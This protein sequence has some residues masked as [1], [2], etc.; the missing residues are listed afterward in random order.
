M[1]LRTQILLGYGL[2]FLSAGLVLAWAVVNLLRLGTAS[3]AILS[4]NY[5]SIEAAEHMR[6]ALERQDSAV[7]LYVLGSEAEGARQFEANEG[8]FHRWFGRA[9]DNVTIPGEQAILA[10]V[11][12]AYSAYA[13][14]FTGLVE[15]G[16]AGTAS[17]RP[18]GDRLAT[19]RRLYQERMLPSF[20]AAEDRVVD[21]R[22]LNEQTMVAASERAGRV[23]ERAVW[24]VA[25]VS[26][27]ALV[28]GL[29]LALLLA[30]RIVRPVGQMRT[31]AER[32]G[33][34]DLDVAVPAGTSDELGALAAQFN[35]MTAQLRSYRDLN[36]ERVVAE[37]R[38]GAAVIDSVDDGL[39]VV[40]ADLVVDRMNPAA[41]EALGVDPSLAEGRPLPNVV[42]DEGLLAAVR[43]AVASA[44]AGEAKDRE[45]ED[46][47][48][49]PFLSIGRDGAARHYQYVATPVRTPDGAALGVILLLRDVTAL[50]ELDRLKSEFVAT[51]SHELKTPLTSM[52]MSVGL[53]L[54]RAAG[55]L[56]ERERDLLEA[57]AEDVDRLK[58]LVHDL[59][60]LS[61]IEAGRIELD[62]TAVA[63]PALVDRALGSLRLQADEAGV[64]LSSDLPD[65]LPPVFADPTR[66]AW[67]VTNLVSNALRYTDRGGH[68]VVSAERRGDRVAVSVADDGEG[69]PYAMQGRIFDKFVQVEGARSVGG[70]GLG[71]AI[72][73]ELVR[74][75]GGSI[76]VESAPG[77]GS[78]FTFT[79]PTAAEVS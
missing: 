33:A 78:T 56:S 44:E 25:L 72:S 63:V 26:G 24:S 47:E 55:K 45:M 7:L 13:A 23:A 19:A 4:E 16:G 5:R 11:D 21:L 27:L 64:V 68:V 17:P 20:Q 41:S 75:H 54:E 29:A 31:A 73:K 1:S 67:V 28:V 14:A 39:V 69:V 36:V 43:R 3:D 62:R 35:D 59:L 52:G 57:A 53:L 71:L 30:S 12:S 61:K 60:D 74:A 22:A 40:R 10:A 8:R 15:A 34:G 50:R 66:V 51:A 37:E 48:P 6:D 76:G 2:V 77:Q 42:H 70:S 32:I 49:G 9:E 46:G 38:K 65:G 79:L 18:A 58:A